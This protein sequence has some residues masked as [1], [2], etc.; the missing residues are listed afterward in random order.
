MCNRNF[1]NGKLNLIENKGQ[2]TEDKRMNKSEIVE[3][4][5][6]V[7]GYPFPNVNV[8]HSI[9]IGLPILSP[10]LTMN[11]IAKTSFQ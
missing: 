9:I 5:N 3:T 6:V 2:I 10:N 8:P 11:E 7:T 1:K 4:I